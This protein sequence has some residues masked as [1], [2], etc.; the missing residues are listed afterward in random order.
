MELKRIIKTCKQG[1]FFAALFSFF[2]NALVLTVPIYTLQ[3]FDRVLASHSLE[4]LFYMTVIAVFALFIYGSLFYIRALIFARIAQ[5]LSNQLYIIFF[6]QETDKA[7]INGK[8]SPILFQSIKQLSQFL[9]SSMPLS[10][11]DFPW[12]FIFIALLFYLNSAIGWLALIGTGLLSLIALVEFYLTRSNTL[13]ISRDEAKLGLHIQE[14]L[15]AAE[16]VKGL[17]LFDNLLNKLIKQQKETLPEQK[18]LVNIHYF[19]TS[20][21][22]F[23]RV[24]LQI[25]IIGL[26]GYFI[27][28]Q[29]FTPGMMIAASIIF[30]RSIVPAEQLLSNWSLLIKTYQAYKTLKQAVLPKRMVERDMG[31]TTPSP[32]SLSKVSFA[33]PKQSHPALFDINFRLNPGELL[34]ILGE[35]GSGKSTLLGSVPFFL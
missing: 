12:I 18:H 32:L 14:S 22:Q 29:K 6:T 9:S 2:I 28:Q 10:L 24:T 3:V 1:L 34:I 17:N 26:G 25:F 33:Y 19:C 31:K 27:L 20:L 7:G 21:S 35:T 4:T 15:L 30:S 23:I 13:K 16:T 8:K 5:W 11:L